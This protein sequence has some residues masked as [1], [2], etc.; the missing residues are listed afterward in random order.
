MSKSKAS[1]KRGVSGNPAKRMAVPEEEVVLPTRSERFFGMRWVQYAMVLLI[2]GGTLGPMIYATATAMEPTS[3]RAWAS[4]VFFAVLFSSAF[5]YM[6]TY[7]VEFIAHWQLR[8]RGKEKARSGLSGTQVLQR[9]VLLVAV[10]AMLLGLTLSS[11]S[12]IASVPDPVDPN[13]TR[14]DTGIPLFPQVGE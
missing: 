12:Q 14:P 3:D 4:A 2:I 11:Y 9:L 1:A 6:A 10:F 13:R 8:R 7:F 5:L